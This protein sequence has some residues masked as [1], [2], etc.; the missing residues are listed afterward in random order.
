[1][2]RPV[3]GVDRIINDRRIQ[4]KPIAFFTMVEGRFKCRPATASAATTSTTTATSGG[5]A[6]VVFVGLG[7]LCFALR[8]SCF[9]L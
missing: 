3:F 4:P 1:M 6:L 7:R 8:E 9:Q 5:S 2:T